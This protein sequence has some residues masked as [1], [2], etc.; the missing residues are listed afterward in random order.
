[1]K[2]SKTYS[3]IQYLDS[4]GN[5]VGYS[6]NYPSTAVLNSKTKELEYQTKPF[7]SL[8]IMVG[9]I[10]RDYTEGCTAKDCLDEVLKS[11]DNQYAQLYITD[12]NKIKEMFPQI[13]SYE[14]IIVTEE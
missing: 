8:P 3:L 14:P 11:V 1:M 6:Q 5:V 9:S 12:I 7:A 2:V 10:C 4:N 13:D